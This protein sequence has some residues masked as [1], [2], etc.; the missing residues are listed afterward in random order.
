MSREI[1][2]IKVFVSCPSDVEDEKQIVR[3]VCDSITKAYSRSRNIQITAIDWK[4]DVFPEITG[5]RTQSMISNQTGEYDIYIGILWK[6]FGDKQKNG[7]TPTEEEFEE[8]FKRRQETGKPVIKLFFKRDEY[9]SNGFYEAQQ[10]AEVQRFKEKIKNRNIGLYDEFRGKEE[11][12]GK[13]NE[14]ILHIIE[15]FDSLTAR[16]L[17]ISKP[18]YE[19]V[20]DYLPRKAHP[21]SDYVVPRLPFLKEELSQ[22]VVDLVKKNNRIALLGDAGTGKT[23]ELKRIAYYFSEDDSP[24][25]PLSVT[26]STY[27][28]ESIDELLPSNWK[29][30]PEG[31][32]LIILDGLD[33][34]ESKNKN[35]AIRR[36]ESFSDKYQH[37]H[38]IVS[39]RTNFYNRETEESTGTL[40]G[41][42]SYVLLELD[43]KDVQRFIEEKLEKCAKDFNDA[44][45]KNRLHDLL[46][47][48]FYLV[49]LVNLFRTNSTLPKSKAE[50]F[51][52]L[53]KMRIKLDEE[54]FRTAIELHKKTIIE[55]LERVA[56]GME[57]LGRNYITDNE[58]EKLVPEESLRKML[59]YCTTWT[60]NGRNMP[61][62]HFE[63]NNIQEYL[64]ARALSRQSC[65]T[66]KDFV[67]FA[68][69]HRKIIPS[70]INTLSFL[71]SIV[72]KNDPLF[73]CLLSWIK[74]I[75]AELVIRFEPDKVDTVTRFQVFKNIFDYYKERKIWINHDKFDFDEL[76]HF[77]QSEETINFLLAEI[78]NA[79][80][81][82]VLSNAISLL[83]WLNIP[84]SYKQRATNLL[85]DC[86][87][88]S[89][90]GVNVQN[91]AL[92]ALAKLRFN[93]QEVVDQIVPKLRSSDN[94]WVRYGSYHFLRKSDYLDE[95]IDVFLEGIKYV[96]FKVRREIY[97]TRISNESWELRLG[98]EKARSP[99]AVER[100]LIY[101]RKNPKDLNEPFLNK[102]VLIIAKNA[103]DA[104]FENLSLLD[105][106]IDLFVTLLNEYLNETARK[107][108]SFFEKTGTRFEVFRKFFSQLNKNRKD[109]LLILASLADEKTI[110][111]FAQQYVDHDITDD[112]VL[113]FRHYLSWKNSNLF[114][115]FNRLMNEKSG[116]KF[117]LPPIR[118]FDE[119]KR[120]RTQRDI[121][122]LF[123]KQAFLS[124]IK[125]IFDTEKKET[126]TRDELLKMESEYW[127]NQYFSDL[128]LDTLYD[129]ARNEAITFEKAVQVVD[130][131]D[132]DLF[133]ISKI[134]NYMTSR[135]EAA[136]SEDQESW[137][138]K[139][140]DSHIRD[141]D[142]KTVLVKKSDGQL[143]TDW[144]AIYLWYFLRKLN[145]TYPKDI[146]LDM[147]SFDSIEKYEWIGIGYLE[148]LLKEDDMIAR[149]LE[150]LQNGIKNDIVLKN[151]IEYCRR[152]DIKE[153]LPFALS[154]IAN[155]DRGYQ[156]RQASLETVYE[157]SE[158]ISGLEQILLVI[159]DDFK[160]DVVGKLLKHES[161][162]CH[163]FLLGELEG[164]SE[165]DQIKAA[166][167]LIQMQ[168]L[169]GL[170][171]Y[172]EWVEEHKELP[173]AVFDKSPIHSLRKVES[174][175]LLIRL[176]RISYQERLYEDFFRRIDNAARNA[177]MEIA[178]Q[179]EENYLEVREA[180]ERFIKENTSII[181]NVEF[182]DYFL[183]S[184]DMRHYMSKSKKVDI[185]D[186]IEKLE[187]VQSHY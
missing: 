136:L 17:Q 73:D 127:D 99:E 185:D 21:T 74:D 19:E 169:N 118:D 42:S 45:Y 56:L 187:K 138:G 48:P 72:D 71:F 52:Q 134:Y 168:D 117:V 176:L 2:Q 101:F 179:S 5:E 108:V 111:F 31:Q 80:H 11:F 90:M 116:N 46:G 148:E 57:V 65:E 41:F 182:L 163:R 22:D 94:D 160:W 175:P 177:L 102:S 84:Y 33:E 3:D 180:V 146:F 120:K 89:D 151:H 153:V 24:F 173:Y 104:Y 147:L 114:L 82:T 149:I 77:G 81:H 87:L 51:E 154:E 143:S 123:D 32:R 105:I 121:E 122:L 10:A 25:Y 115:P 69:A 165:Q 39:S 133:C 158:T 145:L 97:E 161:K 76:A 27:V 170:E 53:L 63:H 1:N 100:I 16:K 88:N 186:V 130:R 28:D 152:H 155:T 132:W 91:D 166:T 184:L 49:Q 159:K 9:Y 66:I 93:T 20:L 79:T 128:A 139:W 60:K 103:A 125:N 183:D 95:N 92:I 172:I 4:K 70:W 113:T 156:V 157:L 140:C 34:I 54:K 37:S 26:L 40:R 109:N 96:R 12:Q 64:A 61:I 55:T 50:I 23:T 98:L 126:F 15:E 30:I 43:D 83:E 78:E 144:R 62:W 86:A 167:Y 150:N 68:P 112:D 164:G 8:A 119:E 36:I 13:V 131:R 174:I 162:Y 171:Y 141:I 38:I 7:L 135:E 110:E 67:S 35:D 59:N 129:I 178:L 181:R 18:K 44:I 75:E 142:F 29:E 47:I 85:V 124:E 58:F 137:I 14:S 6:R 106:A 107:F